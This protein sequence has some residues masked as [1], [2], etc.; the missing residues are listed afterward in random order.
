MLEADK[1]KAIFCLHHE[2]MGAR[3]ISRRLGVSRNT[4]RSVIAQAGAMPQT[5][6]SH[7]V[8]IDEGLLRTL[9][10][11]CAG[12]VQR[13]HEMLV[14]EEKIPIKYSTLTRLLRVLHI[15]QPSKT[16]CD[17]VPDEPG[18]EMQHDTS[19]YVLLLNKEKTH[20]VA[21]LLY[22]RYS[23]RRYLKFY[24]SFQR[25]KMKCFF[26]EALMFW[27]YC[28]R[29]C[30]I[31]NTNLARLSG[32]GKN[33][34]IVPEMESFSRQ[35]GFS[36]HCHEVKHSDRKA[37]E[38]RSFWTV[39]T[40]FLPGRTFDSLEDLNSQALEWS[41]VRMEHR[42][43][44]KAKLIPAKVFEYES[45]FLTKL[46]SHLPAPY[47]VHNR[48]TDQYGDISFNGNFYWVPGTAR[49][50]I[51]VVE[52]S[53]MIALYRA[54]ENLIE[55]QQPADQVRNKLFIPEGTKAAPHHQPKNRKNRSDEELQLL[56]AIGQSVQAYLDF[57]LASKGITRH[58]FLRKLARLS[59]TMTQTIF[60]QSIERAHRYRITDIAVIE[61]I[62]VLA[63]GG[64]CYELPNAEVNA[65]FE[66]REAYREGA[67]TESPDMTV[68]D[69]INDSS[70]ELK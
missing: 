56:R 15:S 47:L 22:M 68:Y 58:E 23:K 48:C 21:S 39:E 60:T 44:T 32:T 61:R 51:K 55:Y 38:E 59:R 30:I 43:Q 46:P 20:V 36:F 13:V 49:A 67:L 3:E 12:R 29:D 2:G 18:V 27:G 4:V 28:A 11:K 8:G 45:T 69:E 52:Y 1:R 54:R 63:I 66:E 34:L 5:S 6:R 25:F 57:A 24:R 33:A 31:D 35:Y 64:S 53:G 65:A 42:P 7:K 41:T 16:R 19:P 26:H 37:G 9:Y 62:A 50:D 14:E 40:N 10:Q 70:D 17:R